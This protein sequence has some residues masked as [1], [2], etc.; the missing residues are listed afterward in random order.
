MS[1]DEG[2]PHA[3][4]ATAKH[5]DPKFRA[6]WRN[7]RNEAAMNAAVVLYEAVQLASWQHGERVT[8]EDAAPSWMTEIEQPAKALVKAGLLDREQR[9]PVHAWEHWFGPPRERRQHLRDKW[10]RAA[11]RQ[12]NRAVSTGDSAA[13]PPRSNGGSATPHTHT[14]RQTN[15]QATTT[16]AQPRNGAAGQ[17]DVAAPAAQQ[18]GSES[19]LRRNPD[20]DKWERRNPDTGDWEVGPAEEVDHHYPPGGQQ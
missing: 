2:F 20:T 6:L 17:R 18:G 14:D 8:A 16:G 9:I 13:V 15:K 10:V 5:N 1:R 3:D 12:R 11:R 19:G 7:L 4:V